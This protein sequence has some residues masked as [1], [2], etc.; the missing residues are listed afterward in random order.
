MSFVDKTRN[1][2]SRNVRLGILIATAV[3]ALD[4]ASFVDPV[5]QPASYHEFAATGPVWGITHFGN[6]VSNIG[7]LIFGALGLWS[8]TG[9][10]GQATFGDSRER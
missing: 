2:L 3:V 1:G 8:V 4:A 6:V 9:A 10:R 5:A 7:F